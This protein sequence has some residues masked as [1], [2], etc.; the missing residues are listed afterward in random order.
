M[1]TTGT[2]A[3]Y[4]A[5]DERFLHPEIQQL[6]GRRSDVLRALGI[7][8]EA[9]TED[10][11]ECL[12]RLRRREEQG[13]DRDVP[14]ALILYQAL[15]ERAFGRGERASGEMSL[16]SVLRVFGE[17]SGLVLTDSGW[18]RPSQCLHGAPLFG[19][20]RAFAPTFP[21]SE[22]FWQRLAVRLPTVDDATAVIKEL[23][24]QDRKQGRDEPDG[25]TQSIVLE[26]LKMLAALGRTD[27]GALTARRLG[28]LPLWTSQG[29]RS[30]RPVYAVEDP[31]VAEALGRERAVWCPGVELEQIQP[32]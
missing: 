30:K 2:V 25:T 10:L 22:E 31:V 12:Q 14:A 28:R 13:G 27:P 24:Q 9:R 6:V 15:A 11:V 16:G 4:G 29:W 26:T 1:R 17:G 18:R 23:A 21:G 3:V 20:L 5:D 8:A 7:S 19:P 32:R